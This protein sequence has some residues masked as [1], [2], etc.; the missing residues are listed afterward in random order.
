LGLSRDAAV[1]PHLNN[2]FLAAPT[3]PFGIDEL[4][5]G[6][7][8]KGEGGGGEG[9]EGGEG[10]DEGAQ[11]DLTEYDS[12]NLTTLEKIYLFSRS[13]V[14]FHRVFIARSMAGFLRYGVSGHGHSPQPR[15][16]S[17]H[18]EEGGREGVVGEN[19]S[20]AMMDQISPGE[21]VKY[22][23]PLLN[24]LAM[25]EDEAVKEA[26]AAELVPIIWWF[27]THCKVVDEEPYTDLDQDYQ[28]GNE[29]YS[30][31]EQGYSEENPDDADRNLLQISSTRTVDLEVSP[32][33]PTLHLSELANTSS[34]TPP[35]Q[36]NDRR[37]PSSS[38]PGVASPR[39]TPLSVQSFTPILGTLLLSPN[40]LVGGPTRYAVVE[41]LRRVR[42]ADQARGE[43]GLAPTSSFF[44]FGIFFER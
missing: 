23:L 9:G 44:G 39:P 22:V 27:I 4:G 20:E 32:L 24:G 29:G 8:G 37:S 40:S 7:L 36:P 16:S 5:R 11:L 14:G 31:E 34:S 12:E 6:E 1:S 21:A 43:T 28:F 26:L 17:L 18:E 19:D 33:P 38:Q 10:V 25:D 41:L 35:S 2:P 3:N 15:P 42:R 13:S 30:E